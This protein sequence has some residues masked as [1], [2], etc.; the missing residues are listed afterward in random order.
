MTQALYKLFLVE[1]SGLLGTESSS[2]LR[3]P[4]VL[5]WSPKGVGGAE[6]KSGSYVF[7]SPVEES[8]P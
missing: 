4:V 7:R 5:W 2:E 6:E 1:E 8:A 3:C